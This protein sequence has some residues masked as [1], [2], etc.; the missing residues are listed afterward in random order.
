VELFEV[1]R[2]VLAAVITV[3]ILWPVNVPV[4]ALAYK[5]RQ[6]Q[7]AI[8]FEKSAFW[9]RCAFA[10]LGLAGMSV[11]LALLD[12]WLAGAVAPPGPTHLVLFMV[13]VPVAAWYLF[14]LFA[15]DDLLGGLSVFV[16]YI[17]L[18]GLPLILIERG[19]GFWHPLRAALG[20]LPEVPA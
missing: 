4:I 20:W 14:V 15:S 18:P 6:G 7:A 12:Y 3:T 5:I 19:F 16:L 17:C 11:V 13:Y 2:L 9:L 8:P 10:A 1:F